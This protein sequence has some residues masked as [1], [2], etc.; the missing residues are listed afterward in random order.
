MTNEEQRTI[1][2][3]NKF[4]LEVPL[5]KSFTFDLEGDD[6]EELGEVKYFMK[7]ID[8]YCIT[9]QKESVFQAIKQPGYDAFR[10]KLASEQRFE[11]TPN[12]M[13]KIELFCTRNTSHRLHYIFIVDNNNLIKIG[14][15]PSIADLA[16]YEIQKYRPILPNEVYKEF[17]RAVG[18]VS[19]GVGIGAF[20]YLRRIFEGLI[21][22]AHGRAETETD[23]DEGVYQVSHM[24][25]KINLLKEFLPPF[26]VEHKSLYSILSKGIHDLSEEEC[27]GAF[28][29]VKAGIE[30]ILDEEISEQERKAK[31]AEA[32]KAISK[33]TGE[34]KGS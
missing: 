9:C 26:M 22:K 7:N 19:H 34:I 31:E 1:P 2:S 11:L 23:W 28:P 18:L 16:S 5:Y 14:Q 6:Y 29:I 33:L 24:D 20:V 15:Y 21:L 4:L 10:G 13:F 8:C 32:R 25:E 17:S 30:M 27:L 12:H 3:P